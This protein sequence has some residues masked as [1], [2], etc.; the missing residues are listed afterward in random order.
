ML[1]AFAP[2]AEP[3]RRAGR[4]LDARP[5]H[6]EGAASW[7]GD[8]F[9][10][11]TTA[12]GQTYDPDGITAAHRSLPCGTRLRV[13]HQGRSVEV[14]ITDRG[15]YVQGRFLDLSRGAF[16]RLAPLVEGVIDVR[17]TLLPTPSG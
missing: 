16:R 7:Y 12:C 11:R 1:T 5:I 2:A 3:D 4:S 13:E 17:A 10:G 15:P 6:L 9:A 14:T 8:F